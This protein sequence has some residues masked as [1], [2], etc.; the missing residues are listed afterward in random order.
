MYTLTYIYMHT[1]TYTQTYMHT[2][3]HVY[4][5]IHPS[6]YLIPT[7]TWV[8]PFKQVPR[9]NTQGFGR[10]AASSNFD[11]F[12]FENFLSGKYTHVHDF[13]YFTL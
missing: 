1:Y 10:C 11:L 12:I 3:T 7:L 4:W 9:A 5:H 8:C 6:T 13:A 2:C